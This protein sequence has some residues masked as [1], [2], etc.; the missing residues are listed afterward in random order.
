VG[1]LHGL[2]EVLADVALER[3][4]ERV[5]VAEVVVHDERG[6]GWAFIDEEKPGD[7]LQDPFAFAF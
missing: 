6:L 3:Q 7:R 4:H 5:A 1:D 2:V